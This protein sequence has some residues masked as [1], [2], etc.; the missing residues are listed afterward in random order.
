M[1]ESNSP[2]QSAECTMIDVASET[3]PLSKATTRLAKGLWGGWK[4]PA[5]VLDAAAASLLDARYRDG[6]NPQH[7]DTIQRELNGQLKSFRAGYV[8]RRACAAKRLWD[9]ALKGQ[10]PVYLVPGNRKSEASQPCPES[11]DCELEPPPP[12]P[13][14]PES[15]V[16]ISTDVVRRLDC[17]P[18]DASRSRDPADPQEGR[19]S[20]AL[21]DAHEWAACGEE[22]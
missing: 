11:D 2:N 17:P 19:R 3:W 13:E 8:P 16:Q 20:K 9:A 4:R 15:P 6:A 12:R 7:N 22:G 14:W 1:P 5:A 10:V 18:R 21:R